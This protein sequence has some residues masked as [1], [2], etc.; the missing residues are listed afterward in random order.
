MWA[1]HDAAEILVPRGAIFK[2]D[3][4]YMQLAAIPGVQPWW[5]DCT[6]V[7]CAA[8]AAWT[9]ERMLSSWS[10][11]SEV[12]IPPGAQH[13]L[14]PIDEDAFIQACLRGGVYPYVFDNFA[15]AFQITCGAF[16]YT[17][18]RA[19]IVSEPGSGKTLIGIMWG[20]AGAQDCPVLVYCTLATVVTQAADEWRR[21]AD[22]EV[23]EVRPESRKL[24][25]ALSIP[26]HIAMAKDVGKL[27]VLVV[28][29]EVLRETW[30]DLVSTLG[31]Q[32]FAVVFDEA[33][34]ARARKRTQWTLDAAG[35]LQGHALGNLSDMAAHMAKA[36]TRV[37]T[38]TA[39]PVAN[40][41]G[42]LWSQ[43]DLVEPGG[44]GMTAKRFV[45]RYCRTE[46]NEYAP[47]SP[48]I[49]GL[50]SDTLEEL[51]GRASFRTI[52]IPYEVS[53]AG[54]PPKRREVIRV[55][56]ADQ[57]KEQGGYNK[58]LRKLE[59]QA[60]DGDKR[61]ALQSIAVRLARA[62]SR[63]RSFVV[64]DLERRLD[65]GKGKILVF[66]GWRKEAEYTGGRLVKAV[67]KRGGAGW[68]SHGEDSLA[69]RHEIRK[70]FLAHPGPA[71]LCGTWHAWGTGL[72]IDDVDTIAFTQLPFTPEQV[73]QSEGRG[74]RLS[75][76]RPLTYVFYVAEATADE[77]VV[78]LLSDKL[79]QV[80][81]ATPGT[82]LSAFGGIRDAMRGQ[83]DVD[84][85]IN[86][87]MA[88]LAG[89]DLLLEEA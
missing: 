10:I 51:T 12:A 49:R 69:T 55:R 38:T 78:E 52:Q 50:R 31:A 64:K 67:E 48:H 70:A 54:L 16:G 8:S 19:R 79:S 68:V 29:W 15:I 83:D 36:A 63:K 47:H 45:L 14:R 23:M 40:N 3:P 11:P 44:W 34:K 21:Y 5:D 85:L 82:R 66:T 25:R 30:Q 87:M 76:T 71:V 28:G 75:M 17:R 32:R 80:E 35:N 37:L 56:V 43:F 33:Q 18:A 62:A 22:V 88:G 13:D 24:K 1:I 84:A 26:E 74:D 53:H 6:R 2:D 4:R 81:D 77:R 59:K 39:T 60:Q 86:E 42:D 46:P 72:N 73:S 65:Y 27:A 57:V 89:D 61:A 20:A 7:V 9:V 58:D 41:V